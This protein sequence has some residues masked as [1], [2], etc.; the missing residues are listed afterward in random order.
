MKNIGLIKLKNADVDTFTTDI[1]ICIR[2]F[3]NPIVRK[4]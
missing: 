2:R 3:I 4:I 1:G